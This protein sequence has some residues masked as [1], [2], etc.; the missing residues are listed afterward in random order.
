MALVA[1]RDV[2]RSATGRVMSLVGGALSLL[3][4]GGC[5]SGPDSEPEPRP[6]ASASASPSSSDSRF[7]E[8]EKQA[9]EAV[10]NETVEDADFLAAGS[11]KLVEGIHARPPLDKGKSYQLAVVCAGT[12]KARMVLEYGKVEKREM[13]TCD[14]VPSYVRI[15]DAPEQLTLDVDAAANST[16]AAAWRISRVHL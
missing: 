6:T 13:L 9:M 7:P 12:G 14:G 16:G 1:H 8:L 4:L 2:R 3:L 10:N 11:E 5:G 15:S